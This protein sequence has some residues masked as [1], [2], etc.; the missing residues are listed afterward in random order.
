VK[1]TS[2][3]SCRIENQIGRYQH[4]GVQQCR[5][6][7]EAAQCVEIEM[8]PPGNDAEDIDQGNGTK[9]AQETWTI[10]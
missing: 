3:L 8:D 5:G 1:K 10:Y 9:D 4:K 2:S 6:K 7:T